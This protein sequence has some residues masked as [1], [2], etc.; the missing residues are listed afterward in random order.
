M[1][2]LR[3]GILERP[4]VGRDVELPRQARRRAERLFV[5][6]VAPA[7]DRLPEREAR[8]R[9]VEVRAHLVWREPLERKL[10]IEPPGLRQGWLQDGRGYVVP[11]GRPSG[12]LQVDDAAGKTCRLEQLSGSTRELLLLS[13]RLAL[14]EEFARRGIVHFF[15]RFRFNQIDA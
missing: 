3:L 12:S 13:I 1:E 15:R 8:R 9:D 14:V 6:E 4:V 5:E 11:D 10:S 7:P 2:E